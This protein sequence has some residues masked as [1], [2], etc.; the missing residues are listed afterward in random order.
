MNRKSKF[1][2][3]LPYCPGLSLVVCSYIVTEILGDSKTT[4]ST[5]EDS[6]ICMKVLETANKQT[7]YYC[8]EKHESAIIKIYVTLRVTM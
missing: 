3:S 7:L 2:H 5:D 8:N 4:L 1:I 6:E